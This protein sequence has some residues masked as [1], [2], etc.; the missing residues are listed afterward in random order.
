MIYDYKSFLQ[1][2]TRISENTRSGRMIMAEFPKGVS[3]T[4]FRDLWADLRSR[5]E[6]QQACV[7][8]REKFNDMAE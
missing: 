4:I 1:L 8:L 2:F 7:S 3:N 5:F 6:F